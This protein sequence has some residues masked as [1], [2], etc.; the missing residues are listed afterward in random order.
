MSCC[1]P[2]AATD[3]LAWVYL[4]FRGGQQRACG[5]RGPTGRS[6]LVFRARPL[7]VPAHSLTKR[8][9]MSSTEVMSPPPPAAVASLAAPMRL[10]ALPLMGPDMAVAETG[11]L[12]S[13]AKKAWRSESAKTLAVSLWC[14]EPL[15]PHDSLRHGAPRCTLSHL[16]VHEGA[17]GGLR[18]CRERLVGFLLA[19]FPH[20]PSGPPLFAVRPAEHPRDEG[21]GSGARAAGQLVRAACG[22]RPRTCSTGSKAAALLAVLRDRQA[23]RRPGSGRP[24]GGTHQGW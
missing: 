24:E 5:H 7:V 3:Q 23:G 18:S 15:I 8:I 9:I 6:R 11:D 2:A 20:L 16:C 17:R 22:P 19:T 1:E 10:A 4:N 13:F 12:A 14:K 21:R